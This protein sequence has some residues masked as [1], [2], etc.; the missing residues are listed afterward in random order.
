[1]WRAQGTCRAQKAW[2]GEANAEQ[3]PGGKEA[4][5]RVVKVAVNKPVLRALARR[6]QDL[7]ATT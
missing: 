7:R 6:C 2:V 4:K 5:D 3:Q 1:M